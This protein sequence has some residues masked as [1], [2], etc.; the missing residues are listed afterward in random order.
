MAASLP[1]GW[2]LGAGCV[3]QSIPSSG[4]AAGGAH[5]RV[6]LE[7][8]RDMADSGVALTFDERRAT[9]LRQLLTCDRR[10]EF[11]SD[12]CRTAHLPL[13]PTGERRRLPDHLL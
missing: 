7:P 11:R 13:E 1:A 9:S 3:I 2:P 12:P 4:A 10:A 8:R 5:C 6:G